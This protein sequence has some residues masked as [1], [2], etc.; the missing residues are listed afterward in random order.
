MVIIFYVEMPSEGGLYTYTYINYDKLY[1]YD[2][3]LVNI[4]NYN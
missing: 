3:H 4:T 2:N 1:H